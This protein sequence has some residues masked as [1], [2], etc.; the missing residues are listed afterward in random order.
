MFFPE[1][2]IHNQINKFSRQDAQHPVKEL[3]FNQLVSVT[4]KGNKSSL[5]KLTLYLI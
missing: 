1:A 2:A 4:A 5:L 3:T